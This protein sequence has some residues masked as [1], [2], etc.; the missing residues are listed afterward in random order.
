M[1]SALGLP[2]ISVSFALKASDWSPASVAE[3]LIVNGWKY[4]SAPGA[5]FSPSSRKT[6]AM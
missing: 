3:P 2:T 1:K 6:P 4:P 5:V